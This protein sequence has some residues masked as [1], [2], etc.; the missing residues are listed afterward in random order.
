MRRFPFTLFLLAATLAASPAGSQ[1]TSGLRVRD[2]TSSPSI[3]GRVLEAYT[4]APVIGATVDV[5]TADSRTV[6]T[7]I[8]DGGG[9]FAIELEEE[10]TFWIRI[11][12]PPAE[13]VVD[14][15]IDVAGGA[16]VEVV[17]RVEWPSIRPILLDSLAVVV[18]A[19]SLRLGGVGYYLRRKTEGGTFIGPEILERRTSRKISD[20]FRMVPGITVGQSAL[21]G[22][23][24]D[25]PLTSYSV[26]TRLRNSACW[27][28]IFIDGYLAEP[29]GNQPPGGPFDLLVA[30]SE[31]E[32]IEIYSSPAEVPVAYGGAAAACGVY[33]IWTKQ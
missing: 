33:L 18:E 9:R 23:L 8:T 4:D 31:V 14:G 11:S 32:A 16:D 20:V 12:R 22:S 27:P 6:G 15:P 1:Q 17:L 5:V 21:A 3:R 29:G 7:G 10:G 13:P 26:R 28:R 30:A 25:Y 2:G 19:R 24:H